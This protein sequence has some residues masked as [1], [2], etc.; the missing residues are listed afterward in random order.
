VLNGSEVAIKNCLTFG[1]ESSCANLWADDYT[2]AGNQNYGI[3]GLNW[4]NAAWGD[5]TTPPGT[6]GSSSPAVQT[7]LHYW[8]GGSLI[9]FEGDWPN[10]SINPNNQSADAVGYSGSGTACD[11]GGQDTADPAASY[12]CSGPMANQ[13]A[14]VQAML[15]C[16]QS[17]CMH[18]GSNSTYPTANS[19]WNTELNLYVSDMLYL[20]S[21]GTQAALW[22][23]LEGYLEAKGVHNILYM[24][25]DLGGLTAAYPGAQYI[26]INGT[27]YYPDPTGNYTPAQYTQFVPY[28]K[29][30][31]VGEWNPNSTGQNIDAFLQNLKGAG[32]SQVV[33]INYWRDPNPLINGG[34]QSW[35]TA[36]TD[37]Y[38]IMQG[39]GVVQ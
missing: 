26:D 15:T 1:S 10:P 30:Q 22:R 24:Y 5:K 38:G 39:Q 11:G 17:Y 19:N 4:A 16:N 12:D 20:Q 9:L 35:K 34:N 3:A 7:A 25:C 33:G 29:P 2:D 6:F 37:P 27:D 31:I 13:D 14:Y 8:Q 18:Q 23:Y 28:G 21:Q 32:M 36:F